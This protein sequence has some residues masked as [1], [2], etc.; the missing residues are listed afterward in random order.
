MFGPCCTDDF[1]CAPGSY[2]CS[3]HPNKK[4]LH[5]IRDEE[6]M[7]FIRLG[8]LSA[9]EL[10]AKTG[11]E[12]TDEERAELEAAR[13]GQ[14]KLTGAEDWHAFDTPSVSITI[15]SVS[16]RARHIIEGADL[17]KKA[18]FAIAVYLDEEWKK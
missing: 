5:D 10:E 2:C 13:S 16:S 6:T 17:R 7:G 18:N 12:F 14:A 11:L 4:H 9:A 3:E 15:G 1:C 8:N